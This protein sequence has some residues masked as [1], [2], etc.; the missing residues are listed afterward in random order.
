MVRLRGFVSG[1]ILRAVHAPQL[2][3]G[4]SVVVIGVFLACVQPV[5]GSR[6]SSVG[7]ATY[8]LRATGKL[9]SSLPSA[10]FTASSSSMLSLTHLSSHLGAPIECHSPNTAP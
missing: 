3:K 10:T 9:L 6:S 7:G 4:S 2:P 8:S 1:C 5:E